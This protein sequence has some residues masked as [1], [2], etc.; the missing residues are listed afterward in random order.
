MLLL[1]DNLPI[2]Q[3]W[4]PKFL[5][6]YILEYATGDSSSNAAGKQKIKNPFLKTNNVLRKGLVYGRAKVN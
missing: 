5:F 6:V 1:K 2:K 4:L 3:G